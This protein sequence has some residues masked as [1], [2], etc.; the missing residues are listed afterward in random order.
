MN[1]ES[2][3]QS[4]GSFM[5]QSTQEYAPKKLMSVEE[6]LSKSWEVYKSRFWSIVGLMGVFLLFRLLFLIIGLISG[7]G[8]GI[9]TIFLSG[10]EI[11]TTPEGWPGFI[12]IFL[13]LL[14]IGIF[15]Q[16]WINASLIY[17]IKERGQKI[18]IKKSLKKGWSV[19]LSFIWIGFLVGLRV[20]GGSLLFI[21]PGII[22][23]VWFAFSEY[24]LIDEG[25][26]GSKALSRS[27]ELVKG[28]FGEVLWRLFI[29]AAIGIIAGF[30]QESVEEQTALSIIIALITIFFLNPFSTI[31]SFLLYKNLK[32]IKTSM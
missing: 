32:R 21:I 16:S 29:I 20:F 27:K 14:L 13:F 1:Q 10:T 28:F 30:L 24:V 25:I 6:L 12:I 8:V 18:G 9:G 5:P 7:T 2:Q 31:Y 15:L 23:A 22:F 11:K 26:K 19:L 4:F 17:L 3:N